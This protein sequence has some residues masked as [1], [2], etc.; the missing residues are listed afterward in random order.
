MF[1][2]WGEG[3]S[4]HDRALHRELAGVGYAASS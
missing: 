2:L 1:L 3:R 4:L